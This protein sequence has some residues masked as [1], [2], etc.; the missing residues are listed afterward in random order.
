VIR[1][2][3]ACRIPGAVRL[4]EAGHGHQVL[5]RHRHSG[6]RQRFAGAPPALDV[7]G[8]GVDRG[9]V[10]ERD[11]R[12]QVAPAARLR[13]GCASGV[14]EA[15]ARL[16]RCDAGR[17]ARVRRAASC[18]LRGALV[19]AVGGAHGRRGR[20]E[21]AEIGAW[22][23]RFER[24]QLGKID[25]QAL[26]PGGV[27]ARMRVTREARDRVERLL[28]AIGEVGGVAAECFGHGSGCEG[29]RCATVAPLVRACGLTGQTG[30]SGHPAEGPARCQSRCVP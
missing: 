30:L 14:R 29:G 22:A 17:G 27:P 15:L 11:E 6:E 21:I 13:D 8:G 7:R 28:E 4:Y 2:S 18:A 26:A 10:G 3:G 12:V 24:A 20:R 19:R 16:G 23:R 5:D 1:D 9:V 25:A